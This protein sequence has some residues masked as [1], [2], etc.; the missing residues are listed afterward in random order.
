VFDNLLKGREYTVS[1]D[2][3]LYDSSVTKN[4]PDVLGLN[5]KLGETVVFSQFKDDKWIHRDKTPFIEVKTIQ[6]HH[7][8]FAVRETQL[9]DDHYYVFTESDM[10]EDCLSGIFE[11]EFF[12]QSINQDMSYIL[13]DNSGKIHFPQNLKKPRSVG[14]IRLYGVFKGSEFKKYSVFLKGKHAKKDA[15]SMMG[16]NE[17][18]PHDGTIV[19]GNNSSRTI[20]SGI[21]RVDYDSVSD[22]KFYP[23]YFNSEGKVKFIRENKTN[24]Y[25]ETTGTNN[26]LTGRK[27][28]E[29]RSKVT[30]KKFDRSSGWNE[31]L[32]D[33]RVFNE[34]GG[35][36]LDDH[37]KDYTDELLGVF[38]TLIQ[39]HTKKKSD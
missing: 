38:D 18:V 35:K 34:D 3:Y 22:K 29:G 5:T 37:P 26:Y 33:K 27:F 25:I 31:Y 13:S 19:G 24:C 39:K 32:V 15:E 9:V 2:Y 1:P 23:L 17:I 11:D 12:E 21:A 28:R 30:F 4:A 8:Y 6:G 36:F 10:I 14:R 7:N 20:E 16:I